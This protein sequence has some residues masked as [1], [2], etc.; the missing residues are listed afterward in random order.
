MSEGSRDTKG[1]NTVEQV[2]AHRMSVEQAMWQEVMKSVAGRRVLFSIIGMG[3]VYN[4]QGSAP[5]DVASHNRVEGR[6]EM[7]LDLLHKVLQ[8]DSSAYI[9]MQREAEAFESKFDVTNL[10]TGEDDE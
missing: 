5:L 2:L 6:R 3:D 9:L 1:A 4:L 7:A 10:P 8:L